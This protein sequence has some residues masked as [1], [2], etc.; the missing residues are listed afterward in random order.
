MPLKRIASRLGVSVSSVHLWTK[1]IKLT[2]EQQERNLRGPTGPQNPEHIAKRAATWRQVNRERRLGYQREG[3]ERAGRGDL[4]HQAG[5]LLYW[6]EGSKDRNTVKF[7]NSDIHMVSFF[8]RFL[9]ECFDLEPEDFAV[10]LHVYTGNGLSIRQIEDHWLRGLE[11]PR[12]C[13]RKHS[14]DYL[15]TSSSGKKRNRLPY[16]VCTLNVFKTHIVQHI[17]GAIQE[18]GRFEE[19]E[20]LDGRPV[21]RRPRKRPPRRSSEK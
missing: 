17:Y 15:P 19:P 14:I 8:R 10:S 1:D 2:P 5:C 18:Y 7:C 12:S 6:A 11:L 13:L 21:R 9:S 3:R 20:W 16:G 4:L